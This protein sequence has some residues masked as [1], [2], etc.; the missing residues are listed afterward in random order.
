MIN[1]SLEQLGLSEKEAK[2]YLALLELGE[3]NVPKIAHQAAL[4]RP[5]TYVILEKLAKLGLA[6]IVEKKK[7]M[8]FVVENPESLVTFVNEEKKA[9]EEKEKI[10]QNI[11]PEL[12]SLFQSVGARPTVIFLTGTDAIKA[13]VKEAAR[14]KEGERMI[15]VSIDSYLEIFQLE[16][17]FD[18]H[19]EKKRTSKDM[20]SRI[21]YTYSKGELDGLNNVKELREAKI[22]SKDLFNFNGDIVLYGNSKVAITSYTKT[23]VTVLIDNIQMF[24]VLKTMFE[25]AWIGANTLKN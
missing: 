19:L 18:K 13:V 12:N 11:M 21:I 15:M 7:K 20:K 8:H 5:I 23:P 9:A 16:S 22:I 10:I 3:A 4:R 14:E 1:K 6:S 25:L 17:F 24:S 2:V